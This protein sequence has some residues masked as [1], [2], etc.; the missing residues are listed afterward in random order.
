MR[1][2]H[3]LAIGNLIISD[4]ASCQPLIDEMETHHYKEKGED[5][6]VEKTDDDAL[7]ALRYFIFSYFVPSETK[8]LKKQRR[9][10]GRNAQKHRKY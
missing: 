3:Q 5:G 2:N 4:N 10:I 7:D 9:R 6:T 8:E 1:V